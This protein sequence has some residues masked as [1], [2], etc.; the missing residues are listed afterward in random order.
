MSSVHAGTSTIL[1]EAVLRLARLGEVM[2][3]AASGGC[4]LELY[5]NPSW[6]IGEASE[7]RKEVSRLA[8]NVGSSV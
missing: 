6:L 4:L 5:R 8:N 7:S 1:V 3:G 2:A